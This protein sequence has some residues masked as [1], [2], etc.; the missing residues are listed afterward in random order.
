MQTTTAPTVKKEPFAATAPGLALNTILGL[1]KATV[2]VA[3]DILRA[4][5]RGIISTAETI[6]PEKVR[7]NIGEIS[8]KEDFGKT[9]E[10]LLGQDPI[11]D[12]QT[13]AQGISHFLQE[14]GLG[15][16]TSDSFGA[17]IGVGGTLLDVFPAGSPEKRSIENAA[18][19]SAEELAKWLAKQADEKVIATT[20][21]VLGHPEESIMDTARA[22]VQTKTPEEVKLVL[23]NG[24]LSGENKVL[25][26]L[27]GTVQTTPPELISRNIGDTIKKTYFAA[28]KSASDPAFS[29]AEETLSNILVE[30][31]LARPGE[32][33][34]IGY[35][36][37]RQV[38]GIPS[39]FPQWVPEELRSRELFDKVMPDLNNL[40][41]PKGKLQRELYDE[42][43]GELDHRLGI[44]TSGLRSKLKINDETQKS[45]S[46]IGSGSAPRSPAGTLEDPVQAFTT[47][48]EKDLGRPVVLTARE[49]RLVAGGPNSQALREGVTAAQTTRPSPPSPLGSRPTTRGVETPFRSTGDVIAA[50]GAATI[51]EGEARSLEIQAEEYLK[52]ASQ[53][54]VVRDLR[55]SASLKNIVDKYQ[56]PFWKKINI[57]DYIRTPDR[58]LTKIGLGAEAQ[59]IRTRY[60]GYLK[61]LPKNIDKITQWAEQVKKLGA[62][63]HAAEGIN[64]RIFDYLDGQAVTLTADEKRIATEIQ[65]YLKDWADRL[66]LPPDSRIAHY[67]TH[68]FDEDLVRKEFDEELAKLIRDKIPGEVYDPFL[69]KRLGA[70]G[71]KHDTWAALDAYTKRATRKFYMDPALER[72]ADK[73][74]SFEE[75]QW[76]YV[77]RYL[78]RVN[79]RPTET[80]NLIDN[81]IKSIIG[82]KYGARPF[83]RLS[84]KARQM[85]Y[86]GALG[87]N[88]GSALRNLT[89]GVNTYAELGEKYTVKGY[90]DLLRNGTKELHDVGV[91]NDDFVQDR[92][93]S[94]VKTTMQKFDKVL[95]SLFETAEKVNRGSAYYG[96]KAKAIRQG[97]TIEEAVDYA[98]SVVRKTQFSFGR[99]DTPLA[100]QSDLV[101]TLMQFQ[102]FTLKQSEF[103]TEKVV[104]REW[105]GLIRYVVGSMVMLYSIGKLFGMKWQDILPSFRFGAPPT[106][107]IPTHLAKDATGTNTDKFHQ[108]LDTKEKIV[109]LGND[110]IPF[111]PAGVQAKKTLQG[112]GA[113]RQGKDTTATGRTRYKIPQDKTTLLRAGL[114]GKSALPAAQ[115]YYSK[116][117]EPKKTS[118]PASYN[119]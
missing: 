3:V 37:D 8:P 91:L 104:R 19:L 29:K 69:E 27:P 115:E 105:A 51:E 106:L 53:E 72:I 112:I 102:T 79:M 81:S 90:I 117:G 44:D 63:K 87:L 84:Q 111:I 65:A 100:L 95:F 66:G 17:F 39:T 78:D 73:A 97:K 35:G 59:F 113:A 12:I 34:I 74:A 9:G 52:R 22:L 40:K 41:Y 92:T 94:A 55:D 23:K 4:V 76:N 98:K 61:E 28:G 64:R 10:I 7:T 31:E 77:K 89:Q 118:G 49:K 114:F 107:T 101:K 26:S 99:I 1:P 68:L 21:K 11:K 24:V 20:L 110:L 50:R 71:Y 60:E 96:A 70:L 85:V 109:Q 45:L 15:Q 88:F 2:Q 108:P 36:A 93:L 43:L 14:L 13:K 32:R 30:M 83:T 33:V 56:T 5:P 80:E 103:L 54:E 38:Q 16:K 82:Y 58:V 75:S 18:K 25:M 6:A 116:L 46:K 47:Q 86:R 67:I 48:A 119:F 57:I 42:I 62:D